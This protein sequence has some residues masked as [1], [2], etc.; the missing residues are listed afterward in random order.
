VITGLET[1]QFG[2]VRAARAAA[3]AVVL[4]LCGPARGAEAEAAEPV[5]LTY[6]G[7]SECPSES[8]FTSEVKARLRRAVTFVD[9]LPARRISVEAQAEGERARGELSIVE[10][11]GETTTRSMAAET[12]AEVA[13]GLALV[14]ALALDPNARTEP[15]RPADSEPALALDPEP[16]ATGVPPPAVASANSPLRWFGALAGGVGAGYAPV[17]V[18]T[19][20]AMLGVRYETGGVLSP[21]LHMTPSW[22]ETGATGPKLPEAT[23]SWALVRLDACPVRFEPVAALSVGACASSEL[24]RVV[25]AGN[26]SEISKPL[27][28]SR[29]WADLGPSLRSRLAYGDWFLELGGGAFFTLRRDRFLFEY[30][31]RG[32][33]VHEVPDLV[34]GANLAL[35]VEL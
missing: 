28:K 7:G 29:L 15:L 35:G 24:G 11:S 18:V 8:A 14:V 32:V 2:R 23:F 13:S 22:G 9:R 25:A 12:C 19:A 16:A 27:E 26:Q 6:A 34:Y 30:P 1:F 33:V 10:T 21:S 17:A 3:F 4:A 5:W 31:E 20:G